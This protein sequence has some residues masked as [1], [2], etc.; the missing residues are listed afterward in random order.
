MGGKEAPKHSFKEYSIA[1]TKVS[2]PVAAFLAIVVPVLV[3]NISHIIAKYEAENMLG[4]LGLF[5][6][7]PVSGGF[8]SSKDGTEIS[9]D[10]NIPQKDGTSH[11]ISV[12]F[13]KNNVSTDGNFNDDLAVKITAENVIKQESL[14]F[15]PFSFPHSDVEDMET[16]DEIR[17]EGNVDVFLPAKKT[18]DNF[19]NSK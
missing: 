15:S 10:L 9:F 14:S 18:L 11:H 17:L 7:I 1:A 2:I 3:G 4:Q 6:K 13:P 8:N 12:I 19:I 5:E 16:S